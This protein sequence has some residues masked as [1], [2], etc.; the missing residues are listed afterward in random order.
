[1]KPAENYC[2]TIIAQSDS[3]EIVSIEWNKGAHASLHEHGWS[4][5]SVLIQEGLFEDRMELGSKTELRLLEAGQSFRTPVGAKHQIKCLSETGKSLHVYSPKLNAETP[6]LHFNADFPPEL[7]KQLSL[8]DETRFD[9]LSQIINS[10]RDESVTTRSPFFMNQLFSGV[11]AQMLLAEEVLA[12]CKTTLATHEASPVFTAIENEV[13]DRLGAQI[14][15]AAGKRDGVGVPG[16]SAANFMAVHCARHQ[17]FPAFKTDGMD[18]QKFKLFVSEGAHYSFNKAAVALGLG[19]KSVVNVPVDVNGR[20][21]PLALDSLIEKSIAEGA[22]PLLVSATAGTTVRG[23]FDPITDL[24]AICKKHQ[25]WLHV[26]AAWGGPALFSKKLMDSIK[27]V[28]LADSLTFDAHK[29]FGSSLTCSFFLTQHVNL[30]LE[31]NDVSGADYLFHSDDQNLDLS[32]DLG[33]RSWQCGR[34]ADALSFW[35]LW[36]SLGTQGLGQMVDQL[37]S[38]RDQAVH[39]IKNQPRLELV[40]DPEY[41]NI[42]VRVLPTLWESNSNENSS[43]NW[44]IYVREELKRKNLAMVNYASD[45]NGAFLRLILAN[46]ELKFEHIQ[47]ILTNALAVR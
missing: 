17:K 31:A 24:S 29:L 20:M 30:L 13:V 32:P 4:Q 39:W 1:M 8:S 21:L 40:Y 16:G 27:G 22:T 36:K 18:G 47:E 10:I 33:K 43:K 28:A 11:S 12:Q 19:S 46:P 41:L 26:D 15:W 38:V 42:C 44:S 7:K 37:L 25:L 3:F 34:K 2:R 23:A 45:E 14:G 9:H 5:C 6:R 35:T